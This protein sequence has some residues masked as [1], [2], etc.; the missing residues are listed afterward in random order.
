ML[1]TNAKKRKRADRSQSKR[2]LDFRLDKIPAKEFGG[3]SEQQPAR[4]YWK[5]NK[6]EMIV[7]RS[8]NK[9]DL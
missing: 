2:T 6:G 8:L 5:N 7:P 4:K 1:K 3:P 9:P